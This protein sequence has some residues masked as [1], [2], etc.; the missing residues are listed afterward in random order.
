MGI[1][2][3]LFVALL[4]ALAGLQRLW[5]WWRRRQDDYARVALYEAA[6]RP[7]EFA[8]CNSPEKRRGTDAETLLETPTTAKSTARMAATASCAAA[9]DSS[10][11][12]S[13]GAQRWRKEAL[14]DV[15]ATQSLIKEAL[16]EDDEEMGGGRG[17]R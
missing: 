2:G 12:G 4:V 8:F 7:F 11:R 16:E 6:D 3:L 5:R 10:A 15:Q 13:G 17:G 9:P 14:E 1:S